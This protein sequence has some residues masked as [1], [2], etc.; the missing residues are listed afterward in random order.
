MKVAI[1]YQKNPPP[2]KDGIIKPMKEGG[3]SDSGADIAFALREKGV[4][5]ITPV[6]KPDV[7]SDLDWV[8]PDTHEGIMDAISLG[9]DTFW[10]NTVLFKGHPIE[11][12][13]A[14]G[15]WMVGQIPESVEIFDDKIRTNEAL[16]NN[17]LPIPRNIL[18]QKENLIDFKIGF[19]YPVVVKPIRGRGSQ[20]VKL[21]N[22]DSDLRR[23]IGEMFDSNV[24]GNAV[25]IEEF[26]SGEEITISIMPPG[27]YQ[28]GDHE[29]CKDDYWA[30]PPVKR[31]NHI[32]GI[33]PYNGIVAVTQNSIVLTDDQITNPLVASALLSCKKAAKVV[34][35]RSVI[36]IDCRANNQGDF[37]LFDLNMKPNM[38]GA[39][40]PHR[41]DQD[42]LTVIAAR[43]IGWNFYDFIQNML[44]QRWQAK[45]I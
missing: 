40:R 11:P 29:M 9:A 21:V 13:I 17:G 14:E 44:A 5:V 1:L 25:Y 4:D 18:V 42:S 20:G 28:I 32:D 36:R 35:A 27:K 16:S 19:S 8:Y 24:Y 15:Y 41:N 26:L 31:V 37:F 3:Y 33:A 10:L 38:T 2:E 45:K 6:V 39:S 22:A 43:K 34:D 7:R 23:T 12:F 30:L